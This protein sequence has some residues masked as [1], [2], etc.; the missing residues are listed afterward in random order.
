MIC[1]IS[2]NIEKADGLVNVRLQGQLTTISIKN[3][4]S[5][6]NPRNGVTSTRLDTTRVRCDWSEMLTL[7][8]RFEGQIVMKTGEFE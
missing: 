7:F 8:A 6:F 5:A 2:Q 3:E 1:K 4:F